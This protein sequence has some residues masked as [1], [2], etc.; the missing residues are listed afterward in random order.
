M[1][2][3][4]LKKQIYIYIDN[5]FIISYSSLKEME[6]KSFKDLG[7]KLLAAR[8]SRAFKENK[9]YKG[10]KIIVHPISFN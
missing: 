4:I 9:L 1:G 2:K 10:Y 8:A 6:E 5:K 3:I 7:V